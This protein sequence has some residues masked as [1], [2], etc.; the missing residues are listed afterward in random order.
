[1]EGPLPALTWISHHRFWILGLGLTA[2][3]VA[4][5]LGVWFFMLR[6]SGTQIDLRQALRLY[7]QGEHAPGAGTSG[8]LPPPGVYRYRTA[9]GEQLSIGGISRSFPPTTE[10]VVTGPN[11]ATV[12]WYPLE[13]H[14]EGLVVCPVGNG[15]LAMTSATSD[16]EIAGVRTVDTFHCP[17]GAYFLPPDPAH[18]GRWHTT[19]QGMGQHVEFTGKV[20]GGSRVQVGGRWFPTVHVRLTLSFSGSESGTNP[21]DYWV[22]TQDGLILQERE[23]VDVGEASGPFGAV[24]YSEQVR[25]AID[26]VAPIR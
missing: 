8:R 16:E 24:R 7:R 23:T 2:V 10:M 13:Q 9:G 5:A 1:M 4:V 14:T 6:S 11:C 21:T 18:A 26:S 25:L 20:L 19:C 3:V 17:T 15:A 12:M 22:S